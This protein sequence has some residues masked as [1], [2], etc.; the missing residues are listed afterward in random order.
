MFKIWHVFAFSLVPLALV[1]CG[2]IVGSIYFEGGDSEAE[3]FPTPAPAAAQ[4]PPPTPIAGATALELRAV[5]SVFSTRTLTAAAGQPVQ[6]RFDN[7]DPGLIHN[8]AFFTNSQKTTLIYRSA[9]AAGPKVEDLTFPAPSAPGNYFFVCEA[10]PD[11][12][13]GTFRVN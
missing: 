6:L 5:N 1:L 8:V 10:H 11:T 7:A 3:I 12:M 2:V 13:T 4:V 9:P